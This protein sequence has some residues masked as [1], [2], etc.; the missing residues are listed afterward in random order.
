MSKGKQRMVTSN[1]STDMPNEVPAMNEMVAEAT[2]APSHIVRLSGGLRGLVVV[3]QHPD[4]SDEPVSLVSDGSLVNLLETDMPEAERWLKIEH[5]GNVG[6]VS[7]D[8]VNV[9]VYNENAV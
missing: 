7:A 1:P 2:P 6:Y 5:Q 4:K 8:L 9:E 3:R